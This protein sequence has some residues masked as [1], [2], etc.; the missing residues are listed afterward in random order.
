MEYTLEELA[1]M[2]NIINGLQEDSK[3]GIKHLERYPEDKL[4]IIKSYNDFKK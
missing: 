3:S 2:F 4:E 1:K